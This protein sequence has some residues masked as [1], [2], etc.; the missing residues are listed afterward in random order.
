M[1]KILSVAL[2][3]AMAFSMFASVA[4][5]ADAQLSDQQKF[6]T[7]KAAGIV[8]GFPDGLS[9]LEKA[10]TRAELAK[11]IVN[12]MSLEPVDATSYND[13]NYA[14]HWGRT[15]IEAAT[16]AGILNGKDAAKKLFD[17]NGAVTVQ[18]L[19]KVLVTALKLEVPADA[20]NTASAWAK[21]F[22]AAAVKG[23]YLAE[24]LNYQG[25]ATRSQ[26]VVAAYAIY[27]AAQVPTVKSYKVVDSKNV[28]FTLSNDEVVKVTLEKALE[29]N[30]ETEVT[31]KT[32]AGEEI[33]AKVTW[34]VTSATKVE[35]VTASNLKEIVV[36]FDGEVDATSAERVDNYSATVGA[37]KSALLLPDKKSVRLTLDAGVVLANQKETK[38]SVSNVKASDKVISVTDFKFTPL[39]NSLPEVETVTSLGNKAIKVV[40]NEPVK[41]VKATNFTLDGATFFGSV[42]VGGNERELILKPYG[43]STISVGEHKLVPSLLE[44]YHDLKSLSK[45]F[46]FTVVEDKE[47]PSVTEAKATLETVTLTFSEDIDADTVKAGDVYW[48]SGT[49]KKYANSFSKL[50][51]NKYSFTFKDADR[52]PSYETTIYIDSVSDY[53]GNVN[54]TKDVKVTAEVDQTRPEVTDVKLS[55]DRK[56][57]TVKFNKA[58]TADKANFSV[59]KADGTKVAV[60]DATPDSTNKVYT[61]NLYNALSEDAQYTVKVSGVQDKTALKNTMIDYSTSI[62][63]GDKTGPVLKSDAISANSAARQVILVFDEKVDPAT[64]L[65]PANYYI[66]F[67]GTDRA[68]PEYTEITPVL[69]GKGVQIIFPEKIGTT[70]VTF[71]N[72]SVSK[73]IVNGIK[74][75]NGNIMQT[76]SV[77]VNLVAI[78]NA[79]A[80]VTNYDG[81]TITQPAV[82]TDSTTIKVRFNQP[83]GTATATDFALSGSTIYNAVAD[84]SNVVTL[85]VADQGTN[86]GVGVLSI[87]ASNALKTVTGNSVAAAATVAVKDQVKPVVK[88]APGQVNLVSGVVAGQLQITVPFSE[89]LA[90]ANQAEY[91]SDVIVT[92]LSVNGTDGVLTPKTQYTTTVSGTSLTITLAASVASGTSTAYSV[93]LKDTTYLQDAAGNKAVAS[94]V[95]ETAQ[96]VGAASPTIVSPAN[97]LAANATAYV[98]SGVAEAGSTVTVTLTDSAATPATVSNT[99]TANATTGAYSVTLNTVTPTALADGAI[100]ISVTSTKTGSVTTAPTTA[101]VTKAST[102]PTFA[103][104]SVNGG[105]GEIVGDPASTT[106]GNTIKVFVAGTN[107]AITI[108]SAT[109][110]VGADGSFTV[111]GLT[112]GSYDVYSIDAFGNMSAAE[113]VTVS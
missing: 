51:G 59:T 58:V 26:A 2:S 39:D 111:T 24:G 85:T 56:A 17:P 95:Y 36:N 44:D 99:A 88:L 101:T 109:V 110:T 104:T 13:K 63:V 98:V 42:T 55:D 96:T 7:L 15:Y 94:D 10:L 35:S 73:L 12:S 28:E 80:T 3:T 75:L 18:E 19:A 53:S 65:N 103:A 37:I 1:K 113:T 106:A 27:E 40:V 41:N 50:A 87:P 60:K 67:N 86:L 82:F 48:L 76:Y 9:H 57:L 108:P 97:I 14:N 72:A 74:D 11:I 69:D 112:P 52:L 92:K 64:A 46:A 4:F 83:I 79:A 90:T 78:A 71:T 5:G 91:A 84:G 68:L 54:A 32:A 62:T 6:D 34:V 100:Q 25:Q 20:N 31:F 33:T 21:G 70:P 93:Q 47:G 77:P 66:T 81:T 38:L 49:T 102:A 43:S 45:E 107:P 23:G 29:A 30:K 105:T 61:V 22:V 16:Q 89:N 8:S